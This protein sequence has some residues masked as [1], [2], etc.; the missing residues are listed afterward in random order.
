M[1]KEH[2]FSSMEKMSALWCHDGTLVCRKCGGDRLAWAGIS[3]SSTEQSVLVDLR[4]EGCGLPGRLHLCFYK[5]TTLAR[6]RRVDP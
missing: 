3:S 4:C 2:E 1:S 5:G 6:W